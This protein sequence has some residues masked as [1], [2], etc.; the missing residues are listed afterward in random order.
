MRTGTILIT[1]TVVTVLDILALTTAHTFPLGFV[2]AKAKRT[3]TSCVVVLATSSNYEPN[4]DKDKNDPGNTDAVV[5]AV[6]VPKGVTLKLAL[7]ARGGVAELAETTT[8]A[9]RFTCPASLDMVHRLRRVSDGVLVG[10]STVYADDC[11]LTVRRVDR[12]RTRPL[13]PVRIVVDPQL[14]LPLEDFQLSKDGLPTIVLH[15]DFLSGP[16]ALKENKAKESSDEDGDS[17]VTVTAT[18]SQIADFPNVTFVGLP[19]NTER[20]NNDHDEEASSSTDST[21]RPR[22]SAQDIDNVLSSQ[23]D[24]HHLMVEGGPYTARQFLQEGV[25]DRA[26]L[27]HAPVSF[28]KPLPSHISLQTLHDAGLEKVGE[29]QVGVDRVEYFSR[30]GLEWPATPVSLWP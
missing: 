29:A 23:F 8:K 3:T 10:R 6:I 26:V 20:V 28:Q 5:A 25:V 18:T 24:I 27:V 13:Q 4:V 12:L 1:I 9:D 15:V 21:S 14:Q 11:T 7:D 19:S 2:T 30:P 17:E 22:I 16:A